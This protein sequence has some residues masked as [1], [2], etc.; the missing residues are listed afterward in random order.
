MAFCINCGAPLQEG[1]GFC[2]N[3]GTAQN[4][5]GQ[6]APQMQP[7][8]Q[9]QF[10]T[11]SQPQMQQQFQAAPQPQPQMQQQFQAA[12][13]MQPQPPKKG[14]TGL[15]I[16]LVCGGIALAAGIVV[17]ILFLTGVIGGEGDP[18][19]PMAVDLTQNPGWETTGGNAST[20]T[21]NTGNTGNSGN[22]GS[23]EEPPQ[24]ENTGRLSADATPEEIE[25]FLAGGSWSMV[26]G[27]WG[28]GP[29]TAEMIFGEDRSVTFRM[30]MDEAGS[31]YA[32]AKGSYSVSYETEE[33][34]YPDLLTLSFD[35]IPDELPADYAQLAVEDAPTEDF[36]FYIAASY[37]GSD[38]LNLYITGN[39]GYSV[40]A[41]RLFKEENQ[42]SDTHWNNENAGLYPVFDSGWVFY[43]NTE[44][45]APDPENAPALRANDDAYVMIWSDG[46]GM[47]LSYMKMEE[48]TDVFAEGDRYYYF[49]YDGAPEL[50]S[51]DL[52]DFDNVTGHEY[53]NM[54]YN[55]GMGRMPC[56]M[57]HITTGPDAKITSFE[58]FTYA[59]FMH[60]EKWTGG[61]SAS[62]S[63]ATEFT[64]FDE[65]LAYYRD[66][67][68]TIKNVEYDESVEGT[69]A[70]DLYN[71]YVGY[72]PEFPLTYFYY[73]FTDLNGDGADEMLI[74]SHDG[75]TATIHQIFAIG[76]PDGKVHLIASAGYRTWLMVYT[77]GSFNW[78]GSNSAS[79]YSN[80]IYRLNDLSDMREFYEGF[81]YDDAEVT[82]GGP[83]FRAI[84]TGEMYEGF[85]D[86]I[87]EPITEAE[88]DAMLS[89][90]TEQTFQ[91]KMLAE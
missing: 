61:S 88:A 17:L 7:Q 56:V 38:Y 90:Y 5:G 87:Y 73:T 22:T 74:G 51:G 44:G 27:G 81:K 70:A 21:S 67:L 64:S 52:V 83:W 55:T 16:G 3:C 62:V 71:Y 85:Y 84:A 86:M 9:Q 49:S 29:A 45:S 82:A 14:K 77:D 91:W 32:E 80:Y 11:A 26:N 31:T 48:H 78:G 89:K 33:R 34:P 10:Q 35:R 12:P 28:E 24:P 47:S 6:Q 42:T 43:H 4:G 41:D 40:I 59:G 8:M 13:Q 36:T 60:W 66:V 53:G 75:T 79:S 2:N 68:P 69:L 19:A 39:S 63:N 58:Y 50:I 37:Y 15:I 23:T 20:D 30:P 18:R 57:A 76:K 25:A 72:W 46:N 54:P 1:A 65:V